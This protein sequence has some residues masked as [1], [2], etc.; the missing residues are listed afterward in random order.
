VNEKSTQINVRE[1]DMGRLNPDRWK[2]RYDNFSRAWL[3]L[4]EAMALDMDT[5][6]DLEKE[7]IIQ[8]FE[9]T[10]EL[11]WKT[12]KDYLFFSGV[13]LEP[14]TPRNIIK[15]AFAVGIIEDGRLWIEML[16]QRNLMSHTYKEANFL[17]VIGSIESYVQAISQ[18]NIFFKK[19]LQDSSL[20]DDFNYDVRT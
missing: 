1:M 17:E 11:S 18:M 4:S 12:L 9:Y 3:L 15:Q 19:A 6:S 8:R 10:F 7:G 5:L 20:E 13:P 16:D 14:E 2:Q